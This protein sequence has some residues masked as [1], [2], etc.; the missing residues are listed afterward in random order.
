MSEATPFT[1]LPMQDMDNPP[2]RQNFALVDRTKQYLTLTDPY[3]VKVGGTAQASSLYSG[4]RLG[5]F[6]RFLNPLASASEAPNPTVAPASAVAGAAGSLAAGTYLIGYTWTGAGGI[7][8]ELSPTAAITTTGSTGSISSGVSPSLVAPATGTNWYMST[9]GGNVST[10][11]LLGAGTTVT[12]P[13]ATAVPAAPGTPAP[14]FDAVTT[15]TLD[16]VY[17]PM[18]FMKGARAIGNART[19]AKIDTT[20]SGDLYMNG[21]PARP[22]ATISFSLV[23]GSKITNAAGRLITIEDMLVGAANSGTACVFAFTDDTTDPFQPRD[24]MYA[25]VGT[26]SKTRPMAGAIER[27]IQGYLAV[28]DDQSLPLVSISYMA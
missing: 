22:D 10:M 12:M 27:A 6:A 4:Q 23:T 17:V 2:L 15:V 3:T 9:N 25:F 21:V 7:E 1:G 28:P 26:A 18:Y 19:A 8:S 24:V 11:R 5:A 16:G 13:V 14:S 20:G